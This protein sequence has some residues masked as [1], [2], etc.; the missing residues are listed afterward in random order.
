M[1]LVR[2]DPKESD[3]TFAL[4]ASND[5][6]VVNVAREKAKIWLKYA[7]FTPIDVDDLHLVAEI[8][9]SRFERGEKTL[10]HC[11]TGVHRS[12]T[13]ALALH[14]VTMKML[15]SPCVD[16]HEVPFHFMSLPRYIR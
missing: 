4:N 6:L 1:S 10:I 11:I 5:F 13:F 2:H 8:V 12:V 15:C 9:K 14:N 3:I 7:D 16:L